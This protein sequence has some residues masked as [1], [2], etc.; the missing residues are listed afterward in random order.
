MSFYLAVIDKEVNRCRVLFEGE[1][2]KVG[3]GDEV[4]SCGG[5]VVVVVVKCKRK[6]RMRKKE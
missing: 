4:G 2:R 6:K 3:R 1:V 5:G